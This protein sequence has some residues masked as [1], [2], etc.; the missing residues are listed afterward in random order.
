MYF[1]HDR[2]QGQSANV[3][4]LCTNPRLVWWTVSAQTA[5]FKKKFK[6]IF[7]YF[8]FIFQFF[9]LFFLFFYFYFSIHFSIEAAFS[10]ALHF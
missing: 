2:E 3:C 10:R 9:L 1:S 7:Y 5:V 8:I 4:R 6:F